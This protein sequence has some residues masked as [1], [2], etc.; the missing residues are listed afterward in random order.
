MGYCNF[1][2]CFCDDDDRI[3]KEQ[4]ETGEYCLVDCPDC[5][6]YEE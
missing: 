1:F 6:W 4:D 3:E 5:E 2:N